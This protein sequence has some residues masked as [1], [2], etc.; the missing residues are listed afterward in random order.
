MKDKIPFHYL[1]ELFIKIDITML[2]ITVSN[3]NG[4]KIV[5]M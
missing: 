1:V 3:H 4:V 2:L 5:I